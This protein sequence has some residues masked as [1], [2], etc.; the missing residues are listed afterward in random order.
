MIERLLSLI[1]L[2]SLCKF[3]ICCLLLI[4]LLTFIKKKKI[5]F[6]LLMT[7]SLRTRLDIS[8]RYII[9]YKK[10]EI[11]HRNGPGAIEMSKKFSYIDVGV[12]A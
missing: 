12:Q 9:Y 2:F 4:K 1:L 10:L 5:N 7:T 8:K 3:Y 6:I 11:V